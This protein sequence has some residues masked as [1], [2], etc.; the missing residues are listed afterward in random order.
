MNITIGILAVVFA[1]SY[2]LHE[3]FY[4][5]LNCTVSGLHYAGKITEATGNSDSELNYKG[6]LESARAQIAINCTALVQSK[7]K[8]W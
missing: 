1:F 5:Q 6:D 7:Y 8:Y 4:K 2:A 3:T